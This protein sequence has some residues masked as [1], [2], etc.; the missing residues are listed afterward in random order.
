MKIRPNL[1]YVWGIWDQNIQLEALVEHQAMMCWV[2]KWVGVKGTE[3]RSTFH[4]GRDPM[5]RRAWE[6]LDEADVVLHY[7]G[8]RF[9]V[10]HLNR[11][12]LRLGLTPP[13]PY[14]QI[15]LLTTAKREF[16]FASNKL[17]HVSEQM[18]QDGKLKTNFSLWIECLNDDPKAW[19]KMK[20]YNTRDVVLLEELYLEWRPWIRSHP[21][22]AAHAGKDVCP[23]CGSGKLHRR[24]F[25]YTAVSCYQRY[26]CTD[27]G[28]WCRFGKRIDGTTTTGVPIS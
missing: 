16:K 18:G 24:G 28:K 8:R 6:L 12:F 13:S 11:E 14:K 2:A 20:A 5:I 15:D 26:V 1:A 9:D 4:D 19:K 10:P 21:S 23:A 3:F 27:C 17:K 7:N 22:F 25:A